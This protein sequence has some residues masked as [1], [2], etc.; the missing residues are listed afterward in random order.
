MPSVMPQRM[1]AQIEGDFVS[2]PAG[3]YKAVYSGMPACGLGQPGPLVPAAGHR[4]SARGRITAA[5]R[6]QATA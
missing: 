1:A 6:P 3:Q 2:V 4:E 5:G